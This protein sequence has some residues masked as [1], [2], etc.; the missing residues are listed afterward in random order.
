MRGVVQQLGDEL[1]KEEGCVIAGFGERVAREAVELL[2]ERLRTA[3][4]I[5]DSAGMEIVLAEVETEWLSREP[6]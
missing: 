1:E 6:R 3:L 4:A 2:I 5:N